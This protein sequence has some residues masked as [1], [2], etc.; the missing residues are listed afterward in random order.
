MLVDEKLMTADEFLRQAPQDKRSE[1]VRGAMLVMDPAGWEH[2][3]LA[4]R[5][6]VLLHN[7][8]TSHKLGRVFAAETGFVLRHDPDTVRAPDVAFVTNE[9]FESQKRRRGFFDGAPDLA[10]E[11]ASPDESSDDIQDKVIDYLEAGTHIVI[12]LH[13]RTKTITVYHALNHI[14]VLTLKDTLDGG[15]VLPGFHI[16]LTD[17]FIND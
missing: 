5:M 11:V 10:V 4:G 14:R 15:D 16:P 13:P 3:D 17:I 7:S 6:L 2:G 9:R 12:Y 8:I 1:L